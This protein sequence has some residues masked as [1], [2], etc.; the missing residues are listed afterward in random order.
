[1]KCRPMNRLGSPVWGAID[2]RGM[3]DVLVARS[4]PGL[5]TLAISFHSSR[6]ASRFS[7]IASMRMS[8][9]E[10]SEMSVV[11]ISMCLAFSAFYEMLEW[12]AALVGGDSA[13]S[14]LGTQGDVWDKQW[15]MFLALVGSICA[16]LLLRRAHDR[17]LT[18]VTR[19]DVQQC[20]QR[21]ACR[22]RAGFRYDAWCAGICARSR[23]V[24]ADL[25]Q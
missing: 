21:G 10:R 20:V 23:H 22:T 7:V 16:L 6:L 14:F 4:L 1:M 13:E 25:T 19:G 2:E 17:S 8:Q 12:W 3:D 24:E 15:D 5:A 11:G 9:S 18:A